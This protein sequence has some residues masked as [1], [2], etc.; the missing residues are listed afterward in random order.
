V[1]GNTSTN[2]LAQR[3]MPRKGNNEAGQQQRGQKEEE[4]HLHGL[5]LIARLAWKW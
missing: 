2:P 3:G 4:G 5:Q 1:S